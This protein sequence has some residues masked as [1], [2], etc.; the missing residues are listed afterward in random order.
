LS[1]HAEPDELTPQELQVANLAA[2][3]QTNPEIAARPLLS[4]FTVEWHLSKLFSKPGIG[5]PERA[6]LGTPGR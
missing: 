5:S 2:A 4:L 3:G 6:Q 1:A